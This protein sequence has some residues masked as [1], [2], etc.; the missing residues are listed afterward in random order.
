M[1]PNHAMAE[2]FGRIDGC[3]KGKGGSMHLFDRT[4]HMYGG[5][6]IVGDQIPLALGI[7]FAIN[8]EEA[9]KVCV[10][11]LGDGALN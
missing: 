5:H 11:Y 9:D 8:Y 7:A 6:G 3:S 1:H 10:C 4:H 2:M